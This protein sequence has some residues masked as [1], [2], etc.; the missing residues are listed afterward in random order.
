MNTMS[1]ARMRWA[2]TAAVA[3]G[4]GACESLPDEVRVPDRPPVGAPKI[5]TPAPLPE[6]SLP[7]GDRGEILFPPSG[8]ARIDTWRA[9][10]AKRALA[11][12]RD[13]GLIEAVLTDLEPLDIYLGTTFETARSGIEDQ[14]EFAKPLWDYLD[15]TVSASRKRNGAAALSENPT[16]FDA[17]EARYGV[18]REVL[19]AIWGME[20][21]YGGY[22]GNF[23]AANTLANMAAEG[24]RRAFA[25]S[26]LYALMTIIERGIAR[27]EDL[28]SGWAGAMGQTQFMPSTLLAHAVDFE[29]DGKTDLW[30]NP[31]DALA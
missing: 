1:D 30:S 25:E 3:L 27:R 16:L 26:E 21:S 11:N 31:A 10:F 2:V 6:P 4:L 7:T 9:D 14:A 5:P 13:R 19:V 18:D 15:D 24:R 22:I 20:T 8:D 29:G 17:L 23:D 12:G 28:I